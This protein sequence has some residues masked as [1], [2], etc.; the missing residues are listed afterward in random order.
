MAEDTLITMQGDLKRALAKPPEARRWAMLIDLRKC[1]GCHGCT[2]ACVSEHKLP[3]GVVFR[4]VSE[5]ETGAYPFVGRTFLPKTCMHCDAPACVPPC[6]K[7]ATWKETTGVATGLVVVDYDKCI[8]CAKCV[9]ACPYDART[10]DGGREWSEAG[11]RQP[12]ESAP[13]WEYF[14]KQVRDGSN[15]DPIGKARK[16]DRCVTRLAE[17]L[18]P[19]CATTCIGRATYFGD[20]NDAAALIAQV[21]GANPDKLQI[22]N[23]GAGTQPRVY[24]VANENLEVLHG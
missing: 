17:G 16:C 7:G 9:R 19:Q 10:I 8:G 23:P 20:E 21:K 4:P 22:L 24:Y 18:L 1:V 15:V 12:W 11:T 5:Y 2:L 3:P 13:A 6:P 14:Q